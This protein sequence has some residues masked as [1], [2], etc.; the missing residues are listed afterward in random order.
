[1]G[2]QDGAEAHVKTPRALARTARVMSRAISSSAPNQHAS[3]VPRKRCSFVISESPGADTLPYIAPFIPFIGPRRSQ[4]LSRAPG[5][6]RFAH[7]E[8]TVGA[9][10]ESAFP[11]RFDVCIFICVLPRD[12]IYECLS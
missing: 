3:R 5:S 4:I 10:R 1:V 9:S 6:T 2:V 11:L 8:R 12:G 7:S